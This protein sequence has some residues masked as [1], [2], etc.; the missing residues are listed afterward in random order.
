MEVIL[1][2]LIIFIVF[3]IINGVKIVPQKEAWVVERFGKY[4]RTLE[5]GLNFIIPFIDYVRAKV[6]LK[7]QVIEIPPQEVITKDNVL[8]SID[9]VCYFTIIDPVAATYNI[10]RLVYAIIQT[11]QT[12]L[13]DIVGSM[14]LD[15]ILSSREKINAK[16]KESLQGASKSWGVLINRVEVKEIKPPKNIADAMSMLIEADRKKRAMILEAEGKRRSQ[17]L[18]AEGFKL[19]KMQEAE[20]IERI[21]QAQANAVRSVREAVNDPQL[22]G[23]LLL[24]DNYIKALEELSKSNNSKIIVLPASVEGLLN[25]IGKDKRE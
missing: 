11:V 23:L 6:S 16:I 13:R 1:I 10:E 15:E 21:G 9:T 17:E 7:E 24:G 3:L 5:A 12:N 25:L 20:A 2:F 14:E 8:V 19:A 22:A 18:E 4:N